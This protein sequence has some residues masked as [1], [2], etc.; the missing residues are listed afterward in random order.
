MYEY[1]PT[2]RDGASNIDNLG[3]IPGYFPSSFGPKIA[4]PAQVDELAAHEE[5]VGKVTTFESHVTDQ[6]FVQPKEF[7]EELGR[8]K[9]QQKNLVQ[10][11]AGI[12]SAADKKIREASYGEFA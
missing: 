5:W 1:N 7:W 11:L 3:S 2:R 8:E 12:L 4:K 9:G 6:D 10:N